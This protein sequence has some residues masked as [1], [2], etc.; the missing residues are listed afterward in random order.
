M[1]LHLIV[2]SSKKHRHALNSRL[3]WANMVRFSM[4]DNNVLRLNKIREAGNKSLENKKPVILALEDWPKSLI[5]SLKEEGWFVRLYLPADVSPANRPGLQ[6]HLEEIDYCADIEHICIDIVRSHGSSSNCHDIDVTKKQFYVYVIEEITQLGPVVRYVGK[7]TYN[8]DGKTYSRMACHEHM[9]EKSSL[10]REVY[11]RGNHLEIRV[12]ATF[13]EESDAHHSEVDHI[14]LCLDSGAPIIN[15]TTGGDS[16]WT[17]SKES[18]RK[19]SESRMGIF[20]GIPLKEEHKKKLKE[21]AMRRASDPQWRANHSAKMKGKVKGPMTEDRKLKISEAVKGYRH[22]DATK[23]AMK[24]AAKE[25]TFCEVWVYAN[26]EPYY[27][28]PGQMVSEE[29]P[30]IRCNGQGKSSIEKVVDKAKSKGQE[31]TFRVVKTAHRDEFRQYWYEMWG[32]HLTPNKLGAAALLKYRSLK[33]TGPIVSAV[34]GASGCGKSHLL[35]LL[36]EDVEALVVY[37]DYTSLEAMCDIVARNIEKCPVVELNNRK[38][39]FFLNWC[40]ENNIRYK[41]YC[42]KTDAETVIAQRTLRREKSGIKPK[43]Y[44]VDKV[45]EAIK[46]KENLCSKY[47]GTISTFGEVYSSITE[48]TRSCNNL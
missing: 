15:K 44:E 41:L 46:S 35:N 14:K 9:S 43:A 24:S 8:P 4:I 40:I 17:L 32:E 19:M 34:I 11:G 6:D 22:E 2:Y 16:G 33:E 5:E 45:I 25:R 30:Y 42:I 23:A 12:V 36:S 31:V 37:S 1:V 28:V 47:G 7:G 21:A 26:G 18:R 13:D 10:Y 20:K 38:E 39:S 29:Y 27:T 3:Y 48:N